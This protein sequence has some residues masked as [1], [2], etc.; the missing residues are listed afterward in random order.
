M[1]LFLEGE[2]IL[3]L[4]FEGELIETL[5]FEGEV[6]A[7]KPT[8]TTQP[9]GGTITDA[10]SKTLSVVA[11]GLGSTMSYQW[12]KSDGSAISGAT[13][14]SYT[15]N[16]A[17]TGS[18]GFY[19][20]VTGFGGYTQTDT[21]T[22]IVE[23]AVVT[24]VITTNPSSE[25]ITEAEDYTASIAV[26]WGG[27]TGTIVWFLDNVAQPS[28]NST[29]YTFVDP[30]LGTHTI[31]AEATNS[32]GTD[33]SSDATLTVNQVI[34]V[35]T[36]A[37]KGTSKPTQRGYQIDLFGTLT[38]PEYAVRP[39]GGKILDII[40]RDGLIEGASGA[41]IMDIGFSADKATYTNFVIKM[42]GL[43]L[44]LTYSEDSWFVNPETDE[45]GYYRYTG[46]LLDPVVVGDV[47]TFWDQIW[48]G[49]GNDYDF[50][51]TLS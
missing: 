7:R 19:C 14:T 1:A 49:V 23:S 27:E 16:P 46:L 3:T 6:V 51:I 15:F 20:R 10:E 4:R 45:D 37:D 5:R 41:H 8:I 31:R 2:E 38:N 9:I 48:N 44:N 12:Y 33:V 25:T 11:D 39:L 40:A 30:S 22:V 26:E 17:S 24:P 21:A 35:L 13:G 50:E 47:R 36:V 42:G 28:S 34:S 32:K 18:F 43:T 29:T